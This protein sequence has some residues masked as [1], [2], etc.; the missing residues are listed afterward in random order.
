MSFVLP[1]CRSNFSLLWGTA[2]PEELAA[3]AERHGY[4]HLGL[5]DHNNLYGA[6]DFVECCLA[7]GIEPLVGVR[8]DTEAEQLHL[9]APTYESYSDLCRLVTYRQLHAPPTL[10]SLRANAGGLLCLAP[11]GSDLNLL[12]DIFGKRLYLAADGT[13]RARTVHAAARLGIKPVA[14]PSVSFVRPSDYRLHLLLRAI[15]FGK[16]LDNPE[17]FTHDRPD[18]YFPAR[19]QLRCRFALNPAAPGNG[20]ELVD[21]CHFRFPEHKH[22]LP[23][24]PTEIDTITLLRRKALDGLHKKRSEP[25]ASYQARLDFE[26]NVISRTGFTDY[27]LIVSDIVDYCRENDIPVVGRGSA[28]SSLVAYALFI[29]EVDPITEGLYFERFLNEARSDCPDVDLDI[30]W[31][32]RDDVLNYV[33]GRYGSD[34]VAMIATYTR[35]RARLAVRE[36]AKAFGFSPDEIDRFTKRLPYGGLDNLERRISTL[37]APVRK[38]LDMSRYRPVFEFAHRLDSFPRHLGIHTG[39]I[40]ITPTPLTDYVPLEQA[41]K[42]LVVTQCDMYQAEK[43]GLVKID[44]LGQRGFGVIVDSLKFAR[45]ARGPEFE[46]P[47]GD[48]ATYET[49][50]SG[51]TVGVFQIESPGLRALLRDL[52]P[53]CL[54]DITLA[55]SLIRPGASESGMKKLFLERFHGEKEIDYPHPLLADILADTYGVFIYQ[56]QVLLAARAVA[57]FNLPAADLL[58]RA[59]TKKRLDGRNRN[60]ETRFIDGA[61]ANGLDRKKAYEIFNMLGQFAGFGFCKAHAATYAFLAYQSAYL[62][63]H[64]PAEFMR[65]V[66]ANGG[67]Y[68]PAAVYVAEA[69][70]MGIEVRPPDVLKSSAT[71]TIHDGRLYLGLGRVRSLE[72]AAIK[73]IEQ[74]RPFCSFEDFCSRIRLSETEL[75]NLIKIG[76]FDSVDPDRPRLLWRMRLGRTSGANRESLFAGQTVPPAGKRLPELPRFT[77]LERFI[78]ECQLLELSASVHPL[79][80]IPSYNYVPVAQCLP[81]WEGTHVTTTG[82]LSDIKRISTSDKKTM[83]FLTCEDLQ[84]TFEVVLFPDRY[85]KY[86]ELIRSHRYLRITGKVN[87]EGGNYA[88]IADRLAP[89]PT[90]LDERPYL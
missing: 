50:R 77:A 53:T 18:S 56:E 12:R 22:L 7:R 27:F 24:F 55:L 38:K 26:L 13:E 3:T 44:I 61:L 66:L 88:F 21:E 42:G 23:P 89:A 72:A 86:A 9:I 15:D 83:V 82:W 48:P 10:D 70:R 75:E 80:L 67:G 90:G 51:K 35:F 2:F 52:R 28:A 30:D 25:S 79:E 45:N 68:Y 81:S 65:A 76:A 4:T 41:T 87:K 39:G 57:G 33:Y 8:L 62:K 78:Y 60:L 20:R 63:T 71:E 40:V 49:L 16:L 46:I 47:D 58:R 11:A 14:D 84:G 32:R 74:G 6:V 59:I 17:D 1:G 73:Q 64:F 29:T 19:E 37:P 5:A 85:E 34:R 54:D 43:L 31:R 69:R 36:V